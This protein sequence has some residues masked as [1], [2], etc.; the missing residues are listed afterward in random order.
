MNECERLEEVQAIIGEITELAK[1]GAV[2]LV[3]GK[4]DRDSL[5]SLGIRGEI[6][7][8]SQ[9]QLFNLAESLAREKRQV[10]VL[11]DWDE[12]G[13]EVA[14][15]VET[16]LKADGVQPKCELRESLKSLV[17]KE[18]KDVESLY[19]YVERLKELCSD[20]PQHY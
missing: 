10:I 3:E 8:T 5:I 19:S 17:K 14:R 16:Y 15:Q 12:R 6:I 1:N 13:D 4:R 9:K 11:S 7:Q 2:L 20:K 18:I